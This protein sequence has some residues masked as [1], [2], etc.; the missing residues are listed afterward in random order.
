MCI[1]RNVSYKRTENDEKRTN[2]FRKTAPP[3][4]CSTKTLTPFSIPNENKNKPFFIWLFFI[5]LVFY[6]ISFK[7]FFYFSFPSIFPFI[8]DLGFGEKKMYFFLKIDFVWLK[9]D[10]AAFDIDKRMGWKKRKH[11]TCTYSK[12][13]KNRR[14]KIFSLHFRR[15]REKRAEESRK[16][17]PE[18]IKISAKNANIHRMHT[19]HS[20]LEW[21][22]NKGKEKNAIYAYATECCQKFMYVCPF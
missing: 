5:L 10:E 3:I 4:R 12:R 11:H 16:R 18:R 9:G 13:T 17:V 2:K 8:F 19:Q 15:H 21:N 14:Q 22:R 6:S 7:Q 1:N 20:H